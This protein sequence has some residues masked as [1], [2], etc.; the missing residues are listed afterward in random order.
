MRFGIVMAAAAAFACGGSATS[1]A[2]YGEPR[3]YSGAYSMEVVDEWGNPLRT[4]DHGGRTYLLGE[5][6]QRYQIRVRN[7]S[8]RR[9]EAVVSVDGRD[10]IDGKPADWRKRGYLIDP[11]GEAVIDGFRLSLSSVASF[12]FSDVRNSYAAKTGDARDVGVI[13]VALFPEKTYSPPPR[14]YVYPG[15]RRYHYD[16]GDDAAEGEMRRPRSESGPSGGATATPSPAAPPPPEAAPADAMQGYGGRSGEMARKSAPDR[17]RPG[18]GTAFGE[19]RG[20]HAME[21]EFQRNRPSHPDHVLAVRYND[22]AGLYAL[23]ID[24]DGYGYRPDDTWRRENARPFRNQPATYSQP[25]PGWTPD[26]P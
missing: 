5:K 10:V 24:V 21:V 19:Q 15:P 14:P 16:Y 8:G 23:G 12:R 11:Y 26:D 3:P 4:F 1:F 2:H 6:G 25:P 22:R 13:G 18:L 9:V 20:S 17:D 7:G